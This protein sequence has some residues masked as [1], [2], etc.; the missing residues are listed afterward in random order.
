MLGIAKLYNE[1]EQAHV[2][3]PKEEKVDEGYSTTKPAMSGQ[4]DYSTAPHNPV[5]V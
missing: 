5:R 1:A 3:K 2:I 4:L